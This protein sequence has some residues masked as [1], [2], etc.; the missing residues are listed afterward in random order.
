[1][2]LIVGLGNPGDLYAGSKH[3]IGFSVV[4]ALSLACRAPLKRDKGTFSLTARARIAGQAIILAM[5]LTFM[6]L[7]GS[8]VKDLIKKYKI[9][10]DELLVVYDDMDI[11]PWRLR[12][13][14]QGSSAG[15]RGLGSIIDV[16]GSD[17]FA[18]LRIGIGRPAKGRQANEHVLS[19]FSR[20]EKKQTDLAVAKAAEC[21]R[22]WV[23]QGVTAAMNIF[24]KRSLA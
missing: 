4:R 24:N 6:N 8:A 5:P 13:R 22:A 12:L 2:K 17:K 19:P 7:S 9:K 1:M 15:H 18:R 23:E 14:P 10:L 20:K 16:L 11:E 21:A 3:N